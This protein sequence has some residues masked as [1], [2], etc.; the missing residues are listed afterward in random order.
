MNYNCHLLFSTTIFVN[1][2]LY[3]LIFNA[4]FLLK[5]IVFSFHYWLIFSLFICSNQAIRL[6]LCEEALRAH[7]LEAENAAMVITTSVTKQEELLKSILNAN[8]IFL[9][10]RKTDPLTIERDEMVSVRN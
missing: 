1:Y 4:D 7:I 6:N 2:F 8:E 3:F 9:R 5:C 10:A